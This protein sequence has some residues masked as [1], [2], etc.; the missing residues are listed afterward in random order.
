MSSSHQDRR[1]HARFK[2]KVPIE[3]HPEGSRRLRSATADLS[4]GGC[5]LEMMFTFPIGAV[6]ELSL[7]V[8]HTVHAKAIVVSRELQV[9]NGIQFIDM[10]PTDR[11]TIRNYI[12]NA[13]K[14]NL[15][16]KKR[17]E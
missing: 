4:L 15:S 16:S 14:E 2:I 5:Y 9:G 12:D 6:L 10:A 17:P 13:V 7:Q 3:F 8:G 11:D 1:K